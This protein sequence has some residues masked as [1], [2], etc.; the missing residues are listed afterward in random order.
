MELW[1]MVGIVVA[2]ALY[3]KF[4]KG[5][6]NADQTNDELMYNTQDI[7]E[8]EEDEDKENND[9]NEDDDD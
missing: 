9:N 1:L 2:F 6:G 4:K 7:E 3:F 5:S 8:R